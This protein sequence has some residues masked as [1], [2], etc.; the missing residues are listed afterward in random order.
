MSG[1]PH[2]LFHAVVVVGSALAVPAIAVGATALAVVSMPGCGDDSMVGI[3]IPDVGYVVDIG[4]F[5]PRDM[6]KH[7]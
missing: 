7:D 3:G 5:I 6:A 4:V 2:R 1:R